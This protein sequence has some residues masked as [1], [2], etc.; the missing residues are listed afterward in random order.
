MR[1]LPAALIAG[2]VWA[3]C[4]ESARAGINTL[5]LVRNTDPALQLLL[6]ALAGSALAALVITILK[7]AKGKALAGG[8][9]FVASL[10][11]GAPLLGLMGGGYNLL[12]LLIGTTGTGVPIDH[13]MFAP[14]HAESVLVAL[15]GLSVGLL[16]V[17]G[18]AV[19]EARIDRV[20]LKS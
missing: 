15:A 18:H 13:V 6:L 2:G 17:L 4:A 19:I 14:F 5:D 16:A 7:L 1:F 12:M 9:S 8:S 11:L 10:R 20:V 3:T